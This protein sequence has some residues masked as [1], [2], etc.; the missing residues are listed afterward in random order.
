MQ[1]LQQVKKRFHKKIKERMI[2]QATHLDIKAN[3]LM[4][5]GQ[6]SKARLLI[7][8]ASSLRERANSR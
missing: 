5:S 8:E 6:G 2:L 4:R 7:Q 3:D 1:F